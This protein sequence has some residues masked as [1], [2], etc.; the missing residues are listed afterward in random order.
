MSHLSPSYSGS[1]P[2]D[3]FSLSYIIPLSLALKELLWLVDLISEMFSHLSPILPFSPA[4]PI[5]LFV[6]SFQTIARV[7]YWPQLLKVFGNY[8]AKMCYVN[9]SKAKLWLTV[10][11]GCQWS[12]VGNSGFLSKHNDFSRKW[13]CTALLL[14]FLSLCC[15]CPIQVL[16]KFKVHTIKCRSGTI[17]REYYML[18]WFCAVHYLQYLACFRPSPSIIILFLLQSTSQKPN[19]PWNLICMHFI[20]S[21][22]TFWNICTYIVYNTKYVTSRDIVFKYNERIWKTDYALFPSL[23]PI[24]LAEHFT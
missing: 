6:N 3:N 9:L 10:F 4:I 17:F 5:H 11:K 8:L 15:R 24:D 21:F 7:K 1:K 20:C 18:S 16:L 13:L 2:R 14:P 19:Y 12:P 23:S 22:F